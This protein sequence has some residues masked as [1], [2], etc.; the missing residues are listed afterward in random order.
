LEDALSQIRNG[1]LSEAE[2]LAL[3]SKT[4][5]AIKNKGDNP[6]WVQGYKNQTDSEAGRSWASFFTGFYPKPFTDGQ[7]EILKLRNELNLLKSSLNNE[8]QSNIFE[9]PED[10]DAAWTNYLERL[11]TPDGWAHRLYTDIGWVRNDLG[12]QVSNPQERAKYLALKIEQ[13][14]NQQLYY[15]KMS[16]LQ[17]EYN[18][19][20]RALP[21]GATFQQMTPVWDWY[22]KERE[23]IQYLRSFEKK[24]GTNKPV[25]LIQRE[26]RNDWFQAINGMRP[27]WN[28]T[29]GETYDQYQE[30]VVEWQA[31]LPNI[32]PLYMRA[33][34]RQRETVQTLGGLKADQGIDPNFFNALI[35][36]TTIE[37][38][39][40]WEIE[41]DD[42]FDALNK[43]WKSLYWDKYWNSG[44]LKGG[45]D[46]DLAERDFY[47][48]N[49]EPPNAEQLYSWM[50][51]TYG[52]R[53]TLDEVKKWVDYTDVASIEDRTLSTKENPQDYQMR[54]EVW[55]ML[56]WLGPG[57]RNREVFDDAFAANGGDPD[58]LTTWYQESGQAFT[59]QPEKIQ[60]M[61]DKLKAT[62]SELDLQPPKRAE[63]VRYVQAQESNDQ[64]KTA[65]TRELGESFYDLLG[66]YNN[67]DTKA[68][69]EFQGEQSVL[70]ETIEAY[71]AL[72][73]DYAEKNPLW[74]EYFGFDL[75][76]TVT[77]RATNP[78]NT[79]PVYSGTPNPRAKKSPSRKDATG[80]IPGGGYKP[81][82][83]YSRTPQFNIQSRVMTSFSPQFLQTIGN[84]LTW[85]VSQLYSSNR[86][87][88]TAAVGF[89]R[90]LST[91]HPEWANSI[92]DILQRSGS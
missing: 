26:M 1:D 74:A 55:D 68:K 87:L 33:F 65:V 10:A 30:R 21:I 52:D 39:N 88:S 36:E 9:L 82:A 41:N 47:A 90:N 64:F 89:L 5:E 76:P 75:Q 59:T 42:V 80:Y 34:T 51:I 27:R 63:L 79:A 72:R 16:N 4:Q 8:F 40:G 7:A 60:A 58:W 61:Y 31:N 3:M 14:E 69:K 46:A 2:K 70:Y 12:E 86:R 67:L 85:E 48:A 54:Q 45:Y 56:S 29:D 43:G 77:S 62:I 92:R 73:E 91:R 15:Q 23:S 38:L 28:V 24:Y 83:P 6:L 66:Y 13:D 81:A 20:L 44:V 84:K 17:D 18:K 22:A 78:D 71:T 49:P 37:G 53:F 50:Q 32:A 35:Q 25:E 11:D 57:G 19:R